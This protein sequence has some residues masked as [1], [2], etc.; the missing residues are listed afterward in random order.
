MKQIYN[1]LLRLGLTI[2][3]T[4]RDQFV[5]RVS[6]F[7]EEKMEADPEQGV[8]LAESLLN[9]AE[10]FK[11]DLLIQSILQKQSAHSTD[12]AQSEHTQQLNH[13][14]EELN[15]SINELIAVLKKE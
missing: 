11:N 10:S 7:L 1:N 15:R 12:D 3:L 5:D 9:L 6:Q 14:I 2:G 13:N 4:Q 8:H